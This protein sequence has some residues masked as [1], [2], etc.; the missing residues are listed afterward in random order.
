MTFYYNST[1]TS[2]AYGPLVLT[3]AVGLGALQAPYFINNFDLG[4]CLQI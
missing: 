2:G 1:R 4:H 3:P